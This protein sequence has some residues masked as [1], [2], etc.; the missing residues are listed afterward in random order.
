M[1]TLS[2]NE[3]RDGIEN[4]IFTLISY[5]IIADAMTCA[6][7]LEFAFDILQPILDVWVMWMQGWICVGAASNSARKRRMPSILSPYERWP[8]SVNAGRLVA[9]APPDLPG[10]YSLAA[11][12]QPEERRPWRAPTADEPRLM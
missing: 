7:E 5:A 2:V 1:N 12:P 9:W 8:S 4:Y 11:F 6:R 10:L 3:L